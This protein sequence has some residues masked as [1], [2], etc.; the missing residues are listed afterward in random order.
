MNPLQSLRGNAKRIIQG[1]HRASGTALERRWNV[2]PFGTTPR[3]TRDEYLKLHEQACRNTNQKVIS[4]EEE[5]GFAIDRDWL[6]NLALH[7]QITKKTSDLIFE[8]GKLL[9]ALL[10]RYIANNRPESVTVLETGTAR[11][12]SALCMA[13]AM[14]DATVSG[15]VISL[16]VLPHNIRM[17]WNC[18][19]DLDGKKSRAELLAPWPA[20]SARVIFLQGDTSNSLAHLGI[21]RIN[22]AF[23][24]A[25]HTREAV[26]AEFSYVATRQLPGDMVFFDDVTP[27]MFPGIVDAVNYIEHTGRY[28]IH[29]LEVSPQRGYAWGVKR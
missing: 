27:A 16:D 5:T 17:Y 8:H 29:R 24:D 11:G 21:T 3:A 20:E 14:I 19:D 6:E 1:I 2:D 12:F 22:F 10:R 7:T 28:A 23:L 4:I 18:I 25:Q 15:A 9:Y 13:R 26:E